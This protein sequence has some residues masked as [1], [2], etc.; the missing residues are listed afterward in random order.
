L[1]KSSLESK[2]IKP[3]ELKQIYFDRKV[4]GKIVRIIEDLEDGQS[5]GN[6]SNDLNH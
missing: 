4:P 2:R 6:T 1:L 5:P 3:K